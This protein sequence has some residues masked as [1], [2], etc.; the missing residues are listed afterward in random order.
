MSDGADRS[1]GDASLAEAAADYLQQL[2]QGGDAASKPLRVIVHQF[3]HTPLYAPVY[4]ALEALKRECVE[5][6]V[7]W[8]QLEYSATYSDAQ[9]LSTVAME[10]SRGADGCLHLGVS[11]VPESAA[12]LDIISKPFVKR[13]PLW[14][15]ALKNNARI[16]FIKEALSTHRQEFGKLF[17]GKLSLLQPDDFAARAGEQ[18]LGFSIYEDGSTAYRLFMEAL[19]K[20]VHHA[21]KFVKE[22]DDFGLL[23]R[24][25]VDVAL[26]VQPWRGMRMAQDAHVRVEMVYTHMGKPEPISSIF[27]LRDPAERMDVSRHFIEVLG[28]MVQYHVAQLYAGAGKREAFE[29]YVSA[30]GP[31]TV[32]EDRGDFDLAMQLL[33]DSRVYFHELGDNANRRLALTQRLRQ[34]I[35]GHFGA[36]ASSDPVF[37]ITIHVA[38][39]QEKGLDWHMGASDELL[40]DLLMQFDLADVSLAFRNFGIRYKAVVSDAET[41]QKRKTDWRINDPRSLLNCTIHVDGADQ[42]VYQPWRLLL[43]R[44]GRR[45]DPTQPLGRSWQGRQQ[46]EFC[47]WMHPD[48]RVKAFRHLNAHLLDTASEASLPPGMFRLGRMRAGVLVVGAFAGDAQQ[49]PNYEGLS[50]FW[51]EY[52][53]NQPQKTLDNHFMQSVYGQAYLSMWCVNRSDVPPVKRIFYRAEH[54]ECVLGDDGSVV[55]RHGPRQE[56]IVNDLHSHFGLLFTFRVRG[57]LC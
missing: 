27:M 50:W 14:G 4:M 24:G 19:P 48:I 10:G 12:A 26:T 3:S 54:G 44:D 18:P 28:A 13:L 55:L 39:V 11:E 29:S 7:S 33:S 2:R 40:C 1:P 20:G 35:A 22:D 37:V 6:G 5:D 47:P 25:E 32:K 34:S 49:A 36:G 8:L 53:G 16:N 56:Q 15:V 42:S 21:G 17:S 45:L 23:L 51:I 41:P 57:L 38:N 52:N 46:V 9:A 43:D 30:A 31:A